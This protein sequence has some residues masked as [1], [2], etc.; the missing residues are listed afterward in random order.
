MSKQ[1]LKFLGSLKLAVALLTV[2]AVV[3]TVATF[4][5]ARTSTEAVTAQ[6]YRSWWFNVL[7]AALGLNLA[8]AAALRW[9]WSRH[10]VGF[11]VTHAGLI[12]I[13]GGCS[14]AFHF[15]TEG[16]MPLRVG[17]NPND[18]MQGSDWA[19][20]AMS[21]EQARTVKTVLRATSRGICPSAMALP[22]GARL[23][24]DEFYPNATT[25]LVVNEGGP[26]RNPAVHLR[27]Q[28]QMEGREDRQWLVAGMPELRQLNFGMAELE[29]V[30]ARDA[31]DLARLTNAP[32]AASA[33]KEP[34]LVVVVKGNRLQAPV[35]L[36]VNKELAVPGSDVRVRVVNYWPDFRMGDDH[37]IM[38]A[39]DQPN[40]PVAMVML[41]AGENSERWFVF[42]NRQ[43]PPFMREQKGEPLGAELEL[44]ADTPASR[45][46]RLTIVAGPEGSALFYASRNK[47]QFKSAALTPGEVIEPG[48]MDVRVSVE[49]LVTNAVAGDQMLRL[50]EGENNQPALRATI[51]DGGQKTTTWLRFGEPIMAQVAGKPLHLMFGFDMV[52]LPFTVALEDFVVE[53]DEGSQ[54]VAGWTSKVAFTDPVSG[55]QK[56]ADV[57]MNHPTMF[58]GY[59]FS[60]ASWNPN[61]LKYTVLQVKKDPLWVIA[62]TWGGSGLTIIGIGLMFYARRW[63]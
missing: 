31:A 27:L 45:Q 18:T 23:T 33:V 13:L 48:W 12:L 38:S 46:P 62:L 16:M 60:Q 59:K 34:E 54:N 32:P 36:N 37:K 50:P 24:L 39:S 4:Y 26:E 5:E 15:G 53:R 28:S 6:V 63:V 61:D 8:M 10:Q 49:K 40:N 11:V 52:Q 42:A 2:L 21:S 3:L 19:L 30:A 47:E 56:K 20:S 51:H 29:F 14:A 35:A 17:E 43:M 55:Q 22:G 1:T 9:P 44:L 41:Q 25:E 58:K 57:W 7:L